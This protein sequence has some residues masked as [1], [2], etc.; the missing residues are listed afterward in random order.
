MAFALFPKE[1]YCSN[2]KY[3]G[4]ARVIGTGCGLWLLW[5]ATAV[6]TV[7]FIPLVIV[8]APMLLWLVSSPRNKFARNAAISSSCLRTTQNERV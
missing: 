4:S 1:I 7:F 2:C 8:S 6:I 3:A 5:L